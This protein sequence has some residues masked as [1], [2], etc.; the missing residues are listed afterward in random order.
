MLP[1]LSAV[2]FYRRSAD[3]GEIS[4]FEFGKK[5]VSVI[6]EMQLGE[7]FISNLDNFG[8]WSILVS[9]D[10]IEKDERTS[11]SIVD[12]MH[13]ENTRAGIY[14]DHIH[15]D[16]K[17]LIEEEFVKALSLVENLLNQF[18]GKKLILQDFEIE[19]K[20]NEEME[21]LVSSIQKYV[22]LNLPDVKSF[23]CNFE[24]GIEEDTGLI[25][26]TKKFSLTSSKVKCLVSYRKKLNGF[27]EVRS[28]IPELKENLATV[29]VKYLDE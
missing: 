11:P 4:D 6:K 27:S 9:L 10:K 16:Q 28:A 25:V 21:V 29:K 17:E 23:S 22:S 24:I 15:L 19:L 2:I 5:L 26:R 13:D 8:V 18:I 14:I 1:E 7:I 20:L 12:I 3:Y